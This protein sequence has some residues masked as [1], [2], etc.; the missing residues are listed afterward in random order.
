MEMSPEYLRK[1]AHHLRGRG[2]ELSEEE[3]SYGDVAGGTCTGRRYALEA[4]GYPT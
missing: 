3:I 4:T 1:T 2:Y